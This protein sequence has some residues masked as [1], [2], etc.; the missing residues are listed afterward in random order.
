MKCQKLVEAK[1]YPVIHSN[2]HVP[3]HVT[4]C[5]GKHKTRMEKLG[6]MSQAREEPQSD[7]EPAKLSDPFESPLF[8]SAQEASSDCSSDSVLSFVSNSP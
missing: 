2:R 8:A 6:C 4:K 1:G 5:P 3:S 7:S